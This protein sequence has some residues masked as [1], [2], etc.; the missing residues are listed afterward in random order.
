QRTIV[1][2][3]KFHSC[4][5]QRGE[6]GSKPL[7]LSLS[8]AD[9][10]SGKKRTRLRDNDVGIPCAEKITLTRKFRVGSA[11]TSVSRQQKFLAGRRAVSVPANTGDCTTLPK[12]LAV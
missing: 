4:L 10:N 5:V 7:L 6:R 12:S 2:E 11:P 1:R 9:E 3:I 8:Q